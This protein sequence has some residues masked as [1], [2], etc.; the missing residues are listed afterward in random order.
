MNQDPERLEAV[1]CQMLATHHAEKDARRKA[2]RQPIEQSLDE[3]RFPSRDEMIKQ[4]M[5]ASLDLGHE[6]PNLLS[7]A[8][9]LPKPYGDL[10][11]YL[12]YKDLH[13]RMKAYQ[14]LADGLIRQDDNELLTATAVAA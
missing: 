7:A 3:H 10:F 5:F 13:E 4:Y 11:C 9:K 1:I 14:M 6:F 8:A 2:L 12:A